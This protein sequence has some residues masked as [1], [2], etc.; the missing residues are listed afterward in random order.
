MTEY[1]KITIQLL[2]LMTEQAQAEQ[3]EKEK[4]DLTETTSSAILLT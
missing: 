2:R 1:E 4:K 3:L